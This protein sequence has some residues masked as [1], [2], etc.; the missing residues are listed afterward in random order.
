M[1]NTVPAAAPGLPRKPRP[2]LSLAE[3][4]EVRDAMLLALDALGDGPEDVDRIALTECATYMQAASQ[5]VQ[6]KAETI[7]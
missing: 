5:I 4:H 3:W 2:V 6:R 7:Q 1:P